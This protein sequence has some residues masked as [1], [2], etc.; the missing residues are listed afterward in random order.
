MSRSGTQRCTGS[1]IV[2]ACQGP[3]PVPPIQVLSESSSAKALTRPTH[4]APERTAPPPRARTG[5]RPVSKQ[6]KNASP[7]A[8]LSVHPFQRLAREMSIPHRRYSSE[9]KLATCCRRPV[10]KTGT[11]ISIARITRSTLAAWSHSAMCKSR[12]CLFLGLVVVL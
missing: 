5:R 8:L 1:D 12:A 4:I 3:R 2:L 6:E 9:Q 11:D 10:V 7:A